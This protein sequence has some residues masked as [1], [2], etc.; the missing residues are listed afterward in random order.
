MMLCLKTC[1]STRVGQALATSRTRA[2]IRCNI[3]AS[4]STRLGCT[5]NLRTRTAD[6]TR[7][8]AVTSSAAPRLREQSHRMVPALIRLSRAVIEP[9][10]DVGD[11]YSARSVRGGRGED[12][13]SYRACS[14]TGSV[15]ETSASTSCTESSSNGACNGCSE[16]SRS[17]PN[18]APGARAL[19]LSKL[20]RPSSSIVSSTR[21]N[22]EKPL[23]RRS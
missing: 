8:A 15:D 10:I 19:A 13:E 14:C 12:E 20:R 16:S 9:Y 3:S 11:K 6:V 7:L 2:Y 23:M 5:L 4:T 1:R 21:S 22:P 17:R 18:N